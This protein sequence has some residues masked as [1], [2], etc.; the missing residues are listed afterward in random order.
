M[1]L[2]MTLVAR[3][4]KLRGIFV[5]YSLL[6]Q[7]VDGHHTSNHPVLKVNYHLGL[8]VLQPTMQRHKQEQ[9]VQHE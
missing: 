1:V 4:K 7:H 6:P 3:L 8:S 9:E 2:V 5:A